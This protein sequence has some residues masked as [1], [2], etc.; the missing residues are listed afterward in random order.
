L[1]A[2]GC[3]FGFLGVA[4][5]A[6]GAHALEEMVSADRLHTWSVGTSYLQIHGVALICLGLA[7]M[8]FT[9]RAL[10]VAGVAFTVGIVL[11]SGSLWTL[12]LLDL[13]I[14]GAVTPF[15]GVCFLVGWVAALIGGWRA[16]SPSS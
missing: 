2:L 3:L 11:F 4:G 16:I 15:G 14:L 7:R 12:V 5:G 10:D 9:H 6:F 1:W 8:V 13:P